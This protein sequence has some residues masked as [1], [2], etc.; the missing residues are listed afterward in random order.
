[1]TTPAPNLH[2]DFASPERTSS[3]ELERQARYFENKS[4]LTEFLDAVPNVFV[5]LN[6]NRQI[7]FANRTLCGILGLTN[8]QPLRGKRPGEALGCIHAHENEAGCGTS[9]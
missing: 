3:E 1:M 5:V 2:T 9:K 6:Q 8:D 7:V 4:L